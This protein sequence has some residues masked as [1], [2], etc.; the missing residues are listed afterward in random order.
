M[1]VGLVIV[2]AL[3]YLYVA[4]DQ[5]QKGNWPMAITYFAYA[6]ANVGLVFAVK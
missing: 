2:T 3:I 4:I 5:F 1:S 6:L